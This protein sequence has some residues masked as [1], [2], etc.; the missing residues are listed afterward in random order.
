MLGWGGGV[1]GVEVGGGQWVG[2]GG[3]KSIGW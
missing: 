2:G 1:K 3:V